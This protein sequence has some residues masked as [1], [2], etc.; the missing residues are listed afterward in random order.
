MSMQPGSPEGGAE[1]SLGELQGLMLLKRSA[2]ALALDGAG[3]VRLPSVQAPSLEGLSVAVPARAPVTEEDILERFDALCHERA[4]RRERAPGEEVA[5][6]DEVLLD[7]VGYANGR[8]IPFSVRADW[9]A[10]VTPEPLLPGFFEAMVGA[11]VGLSLGVELV[12]PET[13]AVA[14]LRGA[15]AR[16]IVD[17]RAAREVT[18]LQAGPEELVR[19]LDSGDTLD[20]VLRN[21]A[22]ELVEEREVAARRELQERVLDALV[23]R[24]D[25]EVPQGLIDEE[26]RH[27]WA[28]VECPVLVEKEFNSD[29]LAEAWEGWRN[30]ATTRLDAE[31]RL[32]A[33]LAL[34][35]IAVR[36][37]VRPA[38]ADAEALHDAVTEAANARSDE[39]GKLFD[40][41]PAVLQRFENL[42]MHAA[43]LDH[44]LSK[45]ALTF[46]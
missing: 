8:L 21:L 19:L 22:E 18:P 31:W 46:E 32:K 15:T 2:G 40:S 42:V 27:R 12:L 7:V 38:Y 45:M 6:G 36:D 33:A 16:F 39:L 26:I 35:A 37:G 1:S 25:V 29:E 3:A 4:P 24:T 20:D 14:S 44:V 28:V 13:Y 10:D 30:D 34:Q 11:V 17:I 5:A 41:S 9:W 23:E 43:V